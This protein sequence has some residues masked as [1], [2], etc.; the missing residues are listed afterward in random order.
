MATG[1]SPDPMYPWVMNINTDPCSGRDP[2]MV[3]SSSLGLHVTM[4]PGGSTVY[5]D[6]H[7]L[8]GSKAL[9]H[10]HDPKC[11]PRALALSWS[12]TV[13]EATFVNT[14]PG[15]NPDM[16]ITCSLDLNVIMVPCGRADHSDM[17]GP[18]CSM[19]LR[20]PLGLG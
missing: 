15:R 2:D 14:D 11:W 7:G 20:S 12:S 17:F 13:T 9:G 5:S 1:K 6:W 8:Y 18:C 16:C 4:T 19:T 3:L 10:Q